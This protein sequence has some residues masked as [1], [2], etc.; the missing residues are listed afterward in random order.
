MLDRDLGEVL[1]DAALLQQADA[2][3]LLRGG[4]TAGAQI[5][6]TQ[7]SAVEADL[8]ARIEDRPRA[9]VLLCRSAVGATASRLLSALLGPT[10]PVPVVL[11]DLVPAWVGPLDVVVGHIEDGYD[12]PLAES[13]YR[14]ARRGARL[15]LTLPEDGPVAAAASGSS[16]LLFPRVTAPAG[17]SLPRAV[18]GGLLAARALNLFSV[19]LD[20]VADG[21]DREAERDH[22][23]HETFVNPAKTLAL[24]LSDRIPLLWGLDPVATAVATHA[25]HSLASFSGLVA[26]A[27]DY[28]NAVR[29][30]ALYRA[31]AGQ[32]QS[33]DIFADP[34]D[35]VAPRPRVLLLSIQRGDEAMALARQAG[36]TVP[37]GDVVSP[38]TDLDSRAGSDGD[39]LG[40]LSLAARF[41]LCAVYLG[42]ATGAL[43]GSGELAGAGR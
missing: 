9:L 33:L 10:C 30:P 40:A 12:R 42:L 18:T 17:L 15:L 6:S 23:V 25:A 3:G 28:Q 8:A 21:V 11:A 4:A 14:A 36:E 41:D 5:R 34:D 13:V 7:E 37:G 2:V 19:D 39:V 20:R 24:R 35:Q 32:A 27:G 38:E 16:V 1:D 29:R 43:G 31:V 22:P 26:D